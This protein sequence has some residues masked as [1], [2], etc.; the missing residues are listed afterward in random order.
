MCQVGRYPI[1]QWQMSRVAPGRWVNEVF[2]N[3]FLHLVSSR[4][5]AAPTQPSVVAFSTY[6]WAELMT[7]G[8]AKVC[9]YTNKLARKLG[10]DIFDRDL[11]LVPINANQNSHWLLAVVHIKAHLVEVYNSIRDGLDES[12]GN[13]VLQY[14][15]AEWELRRPRSAPL[16]ASKRRGDW[17]IQVV[18]SPQQ[19]D[20]CADCL[21]Q[22]P[23]TAVPILLPTFEV[24]EE[25]AACC[26]VDRLH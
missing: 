24:A 7:R 21:C 19:K 14:L 25:L 17:K 6:F 9:R 16:G 1:T 8:I 3:A 20:T 2:I 10:G 11:L 12:R 18:N 15:D 5:V 22:A 13:D 4:N 23:K 26:V